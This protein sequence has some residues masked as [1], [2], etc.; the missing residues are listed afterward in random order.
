LFTQQ[1]YELIKQKQQTQTNQQPHFSPCLQDTKVK[2]K[3]SVF[4][5][6]FASMRHSIHG[7]VQTAP[8][9]LRT[10]TAAS[11]VLSAAI[12]PLLFH[13]T[14]LNQQGAAI[15]NAKVQLWQTDLNGNYLHPGPSAVLR[16]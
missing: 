15:Q 2:M 9:H 5:F 4:F 1:D 7:R 11:S 12:N 3:L 14:L 13:G 10:T 8:R 6:S 16:K